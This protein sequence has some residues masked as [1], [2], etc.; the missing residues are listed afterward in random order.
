[1]TSLYN[2]ATPSQERVLRIV[3]GAVRNAVHAHPEIVVPD[4]FARSVAKRATGTLT[5]SWPDVLAAH[6]ASSGMA[7]AGI[8]SRSPRSGDLLTRSKGRAHRARPPLQQLWKRISKMVGDAKRSGNH[9]RAQALI[10]VLRMIAAA[11]R[12]EG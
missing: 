12:R 7:P 1:M 6:S 2:R 5:A 4:T 9:D 3:A 8:A 10:D 11:Q